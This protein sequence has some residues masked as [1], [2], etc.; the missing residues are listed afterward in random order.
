[1]WLCTILVTAFWVGYTFEES[2][3]WFANEP[4]AVEKDVFEPGESFTLQLERCAKY[5]TDYTWTNRLVNENGETVHATIGGVGTAHPGC[6]VLITRPK[7]I[8]EWVESGSYRWVF[9]MTAQGK[10]KTHKFLARS[11]PIN[12]E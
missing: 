4:F 12:I 5:L 3:M 2:P 9:D 8:P 10:M 11:Q 6:S 7:V 1:M